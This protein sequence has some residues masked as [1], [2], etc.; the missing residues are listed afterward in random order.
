M[1]ENGWASVEAEN[2]EWL[3]ISQD[4]AVLQSRNED[5]GAQNSEKVWRV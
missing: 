2:T 5:S 4:I 1:G 3:M